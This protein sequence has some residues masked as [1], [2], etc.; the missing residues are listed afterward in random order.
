MLVKL[1]KMA[2]LSSAVSLC[3]ALCLTPAEAA[4]R[5]SM[6]LNYDGKAHA[7]NAE[8]IFISVNGKSVDKL[9][10]PPIS[11]NNR[12]LVPAREV[13]E[14]LGATVTWDNVKREVTVVR[15]N[16]RVILTIDKDTGTRNGAP[17]S[18]D[19]APK[20]I[21]EKTMIPV[22]YAAEALDCDVAWDEVLRTVI[23]NDKTAAEQPKII[24]AEALSD[25]TIQIKASNP[26]ELYKNVYVDDK[27]LVLDFYGA[28]NALE[29]TIALSD[30]TFVSTIR[31]SQ[32]EANISRTVLDLKTDAKYI[33]R[34][35]E[36]KLTLT[37]TFDPSTITPSVYDFQNFSYDTVSHC[38][39]LNKAKSID[40][41]AI[42]H[43]DNYLNRQYGLTL[44][45]DYSS[46]YST[47][48][49]NLT[50]DYLSSISL[51]SDQSGNTVL[52][53]KENKVLALNVTETDTSIKIQFLLPREKYSKIV[54]LDP[55]HGGKTPGAVGNGITEKIGNLEIVSKI[56]SKF[57]ASGNDIKVYL[58]RSDDTFSTLL[59]RAQFSNEV[60]DLF[61]SIH[62]NSSSSS[63]PNGLEVLY[64]PHSNETSS[65][66]TSKQAAELMQTR[67]ISATG[68]YDRRMQNHPELAV[69]NKTTIPA[70]L[71]EVGFLSNPQE[72]AKLKTDTYQN[73]IADTVYSTICKLL[74]ENKIR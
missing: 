14:S 53:F 23:I 27:R 2:I 57:E 60:G 67:L 22:R 9:I 17:F 31:S 41:S 65:K 20:I 52:T 19:V 51:S 59:E 50:D 29:P 45:G 71:I 40:I 10:M 35:S 18:M 5:V 28:N 13:F 56:N 6:T 33:I 1:K 4:N 38:L 26:I 3:A 15:G 46:V 47:G 48:T 11:L 37:V 63:T 12:T 62:H 55:G 21:N 16:D 36:D 24:H 39:T 42:K 68:A 73:L 44:P 74:S 64:T 69:L 58:T 72:A 30:N 25:S 43:T 8:E 49:F 54:V 34:Q 7:Y 66:L 70:I 61:V 32:Y